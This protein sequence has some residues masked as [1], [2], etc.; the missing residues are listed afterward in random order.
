MPPL[1][2]ICHG[3]MDCK[4]VLWQGSTFRIIDLECLDY[5]D[6]PEER[7]IGLE[8]SS[9]ALRRLRYTAQVRD[10]VLAHL[11]GL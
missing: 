11:R 4:N 10:D 6:A 9:Y 1:W 7:A 3:D 5:G 8:Q 2:A